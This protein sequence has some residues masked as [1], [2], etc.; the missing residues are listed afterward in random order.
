MDVKA[1]SISQRE[2]AVEEFEGVTRLLYIVGSLAMI[3]AGQLLLIPAGLIVSLTNALLIPDHSLQ[4]QLQETIGFLSIAI[5][6]ILLT[7]VGLLL[8]RVL[9]LGRMTD[10]CDAILV[11]SGILLLVNPI[12]P[13]G[14]Y[15]TQGGVHGTVFA[16]QLDYWFVFPVIGMGSLVLREA[17][18][19]H[20][21]SPRSGSL[22]SLFWVMLGLLCIIFYGYSVQSWPPIDSSGEDY[23]TPFSLLAM[24]IGVF[25]MSTAIVK[26]ASNV[27]E[28][29]IRKV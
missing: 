21:S 20:Y 9:F 1:K 19:K 17:M 2:K 4:I 6:M 13:L 29:Q 11:V 26:V 10:L 14:G 16:F 27:H 15:V 3:G 5:V 8:L 25:I 28:F 24:S 22:S 23:P 18:A 7:T 12:L